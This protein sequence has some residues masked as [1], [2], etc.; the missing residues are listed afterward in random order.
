M[1][2]NTGS[3]KGPIMQD[4]EIKN[5]EVLGILTT[6]SDYIMGNKE[7]IQKKIYT[8]RPAGVRDG[9]RT[10]DHY[11]SD[12]YKQQMLDKAHMHEGYPE[13]GYLIQLKTDQ[14][15]WNDAADAAFKQE[16]IDKQNEFNTAL[17]STLGI[18]RNALIV[19]YPE[20]GFIGWHNNNN[21]PGYNLI[22]TFSETGDGFWQNINGETGELEVI[23]DKPGW[24]CKSSYFGH[25]HQVTPDPA[26]KRNIVWHSA[27]TGS[28]WR[29]TCSYLF[30]LESKE[31][32]EDST[33]EVA[34][35]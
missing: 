11:K 7:E 23:H 13:A 17:M 6:W 22:F 14:I 24:N 12:Y 31:W 20:E 15:K 2:I 8:Q 18:R 16:F 1:S 29:M 25:W 27:Q 26:S 4:V 3:N 35:A 33:L 9:S 32:W 10:L 34:S 21:A 28:C 5:A 19:A 30:D